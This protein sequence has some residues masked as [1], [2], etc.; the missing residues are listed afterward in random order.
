M[1]V[2]K[3]NTSEKKFHRLTRDNYPRIVAL[4]KKLGAARRFILLKRAL[5][6]LHPT[7]LALLWDSFDETQREI[8]L[9]Q[10]ASEYAAEFLTELDSDERTAIFRSKDTAW[11]FERLEELVTDDT[12]N[13]LRELNVRDTNFILRR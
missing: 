10:L 6:A 8:I 5:H 7:S 12:A 4:L 1:V 3:L 2:Q 13:I 9:S 11:I